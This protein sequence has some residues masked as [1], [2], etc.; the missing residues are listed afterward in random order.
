M[1]QELINYIIK[2]G[3]LS[4]FLLVFLQEIGVP[5]FPNELVLLYFGYLSYKGVLNVFIVFLLAVSADVSG[6]FILYILFY[7][8]SATLKKHKPTWL[9]V[10]YKAIRW[11]KTKISNKG[12][13]SIFTGRLIPY[14][15]G[16]TSVVAG[17]LHIP[18]KQY[19]PMIVL[20]A[21]VWSGGYVMIGWFAG[22]YWEL[23]SKK[24][25]L[26]SNFMIVIPAFLILFVLIRF[27]TKKYVLKNI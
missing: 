11:L 23:F 17:T 25:S 1:P 9:P 26:L 14:L 13:W 21:L 12:S 24:I 3:Y 22:P 6:T 5:T 16:Y 2:Y 27:L 7:F 8:F 10:P 20:S 15:R 19:G 18:V 4:I